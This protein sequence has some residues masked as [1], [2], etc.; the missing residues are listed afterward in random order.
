MARIAGRFGRLYMGIASGGT[1]EPVAYIS[2][3]SFDAASDKFE[4]TAL[5]DT[6]KA[7]VAGLPDFKGTFAGFYDDATAQTYTAAVDGVAR[8]FYIYPNT[9]TNTQYWMGTAFFDFSVAID[10]QGTADISGSFAAATAVT[11]IG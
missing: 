10:V 11:K 7:Y 3:I 1:A 5:G 9:T 8:K 2:K 6:N 4:V